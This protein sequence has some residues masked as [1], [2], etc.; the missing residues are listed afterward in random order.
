MWTDHFI[1][2]YKY[3]GTTSDGDIAWKFP[4]IDPSG[5]D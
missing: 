2:S 5:D 3:I 1:A 4:A